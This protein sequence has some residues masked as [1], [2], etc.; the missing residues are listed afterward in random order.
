MENEKIEGMENKK[1]PKLFIFFGVLTIINMFFVYTM[2]P[3]P[4]NFIKQE[5]YSVIA[6]I[7]FG[8][9]MTIANYKLFYKVSERKIGKY[10]FQSLIILLSAM[11]LPYLISTMKVLFDNQIPNDL[12]NNNIKETACIFLMITFCV[13]IKKSIIDKQNLIQEEK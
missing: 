10:I 5:L 12:L 2:S 6:A 1:R 8:L 9:I 13:F 3:I 11:T 4:V 7:I